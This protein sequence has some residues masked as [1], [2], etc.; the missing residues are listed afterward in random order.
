MT[1]QILAILE[2]LRPNLLMD[3]GDVQFVSFDEASGCL[4]LRLIGAC[5]HCPMAELTLK[6]YLAEELSRRLPAVKDV[7]AV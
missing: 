2:E 3:G 1:E 5:G 4:S 7:V 6:G